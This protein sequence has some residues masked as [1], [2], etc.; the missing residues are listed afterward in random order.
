MHLGL[1]GSLKVRRVCRATIS[2]DF[3]MLPNKQR[4]NCTVCRKHCYG[5]VTFQNG[6]GFIDLDLVEAYQCLHLCRMYISDFIDGTQ[7]EGSG[8]VSG[9]KYYRGLQKMLRILRIRIRNTSRMVSLYLCECK[10]KINFYLDVWNT[11][12]S[13]FSSGLDEIKKDS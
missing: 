13:Y 5:S 9:K 7:I 12:L 3:Q 8:S 6:S 2:V 1:D 11:I 10:D 4:L